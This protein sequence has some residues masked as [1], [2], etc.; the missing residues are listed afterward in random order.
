[1]R[2]GMYR[3][4]TPQFVLSKTFRHVLAKRSRPKRKRVPT[5]LPY[6]VCSRSLFSLLTTY[7]LNLSG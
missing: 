2:L 6:Q 4:A 3:R 1:M 7:S 5:L